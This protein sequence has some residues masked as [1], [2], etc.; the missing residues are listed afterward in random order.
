MNEFV[1]DTIDENMNIEID[2]ISIQKP[3]FYDS[4]IKELDQR[5]KLIMNELSNNY[6]NNQN[7]KTD[8]KNIENL[9]NDFFLLKNSLLNNIEIVSDNITRYDLLINKIVKQNEHLKKK[10]NEMRQKNSGS[11]GFARDTQV[12]YNQYL[13]GNFFIGLV[14]LSS[15]LIYQK[16]YSVSQ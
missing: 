9:Q 12:L 11:K 1:D 5:Y 6:T 16:Y 14:A 2:D 3:V 13:M 7:T 8:E 10:Y 4:K 15:V